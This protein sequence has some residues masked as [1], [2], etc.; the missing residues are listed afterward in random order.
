MSSS[1]VQ[2]LTAECTVHGRAV[3]GGPVTAL[4]P[5]AVQRSASCDLTWPLRTS[6][7]QQAAVAGVP[8]SSASNAGN[9]SSEEDNGFLSLC[10]SDSETTGLQN[11]NAG[12]WLNSVNC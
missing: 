1:S 7:L 11:I 10:R 5:A 9:H 6:S 2:A 12:S 4:P 3:P 8:R